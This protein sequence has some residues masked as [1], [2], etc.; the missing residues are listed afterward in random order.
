MTKN[1][2]IIHVPGNTATVIMPVYNQASGPKNKRMFCISV[3]W[4]FFTCR[5]ENMNSTGSKFTA[6]IMNNQNM[7]S[8]LSK[9][10]PYLG[11]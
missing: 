4:L 8:D 10:I 5:G 2:W 3:M 7:Y 11:S 6:Y 1:S 9:R